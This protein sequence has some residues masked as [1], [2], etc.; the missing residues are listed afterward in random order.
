MSIIVGEICWPTDGDEN[1]TPTNAQRFNQGFI[2]HTSSGNGTPMRP[3]QT[4][5]AYLFSLIDEDAKS[6]QPGNFERHCGIFYYDGTPKYDLN[7][8]TSNSN[9]STLVA[10]KGVTFL[11]QQWCVMS[12]SANLDDPEV[13]PSVSYACANADCTSLGYETSC[14][15][16]HIVCVQHILSGAKSIGDCVSVLKPLD[17]H[18]QQPFQWK[19]HVHHHDRH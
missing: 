13:V 11:P 4:I 16:K 1:A 14:G 12:P 3:N 2:N 9:S 8:G 19:L 7:L 10:A 15:R 18:D 17:G 5:E 6:I